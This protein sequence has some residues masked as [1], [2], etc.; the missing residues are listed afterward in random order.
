M[1]VTDVLAPWA[2]INDALGLSAPIRDEAHY[3]ELLAFVDA[4]ESGPEQGTLAG[5]TD[6]PVGTAASSNP[7]LTTL[8]SAVSEADLVAKG[9]PAWRL[10]G[11]LRGL[12]KGRVSWPWDQARRRAL[13]RAVVPGLT[14]EWGGLRKQGALVAAYDRR[15]MRA[16]WLAKRARCM[17]VNLA[18]SKS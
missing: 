7:V 10:N 12:V 3:A 6:D 15:S 17:G 13:A 11:V 9:Q 14:Y 1:S 4:V 5:M 18:V 2:A 8:V 16:R